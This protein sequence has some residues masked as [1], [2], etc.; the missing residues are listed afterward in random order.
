[1]KTPWRRIQKWT[2]ILA[3]GHFYIVDKNDVQYLTYC[4][5]LNNYQNY[6]NLK[7]RLLFLSSAIILKYEKIHKWI[8]GTR[9]S[10]VSSFNRVKPSITN[11][12]SCFNVHWPSKVNQKISISNSNFSNSFFI[13]AMTDDVQRSRLGYQPYVFSVIDLTLIYILTRL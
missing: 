10:F 4:M 9:N 13:L 6:E 5:S 3:N 2:K 11:H 1:M 7:L 8:K 12:D